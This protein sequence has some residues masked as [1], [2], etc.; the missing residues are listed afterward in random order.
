MKQLKNF[1]NTSLFGLYKYCGAM[2]AQE[3]L[4]RAVCPPFMAVLLY[5]RVTDAIPADSLTVGTGLF[6]QICGILR[7][8]FNVVPLSEFFRILTTKAPVPRR[9]IAITFDDCYRDNL[10][11]ARVLAEF[12]LPACFFVP[13]SF[14]GTET[15]FEWDRHLPRMPNLTWD[16]V[17]EMADSG[18]EI[19]SHTATHANLAAISEDQMRHELIE[20]RQILQDKL[21]RPVR[22]LAYPFGGT[23]D[24][25]LDRLPLVHE[26]GYE[27]CLAAQGGLVF[28]HLNAPLV[29]RVPVPAFRGAL[30]LESYLTGSLH[31]FYALKRLTG[32]TTGQRHEPSPMPVQKVSA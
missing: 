19:G 8:S 28:P 10:F 4:A 11:A 29:P 7:R 2:Y 20:S 17:R 24:F 26:A 5:H 22:W 9:T 21:G 6:R 18:F 1:A 14:V 23:A 27:G 25:R 16:D 12:Q 30:H 15:V 3:A 31:W 32:W 13:T